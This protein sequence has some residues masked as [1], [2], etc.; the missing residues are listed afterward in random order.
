MQC[1]S[2]KHKPRDNLQNISVFFHEHSDFTGQQGKG[3]AISLIPL[4]HFHPLHRHLDINQV[5]IQR[6]HLKQL[7]FSREPLISRPKSLIHFQDI[8]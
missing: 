6:A 7:G 4:Y 2:V 8:I 5:I 3:E 1:A